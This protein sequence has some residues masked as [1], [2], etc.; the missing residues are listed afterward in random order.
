MGTRFA[1]RSFACYT[2]IIRLPRFSPANSPIRA[3]GVFSRPLITSLYAAE[4]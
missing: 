4:Q 3:F 1:Q 2:L